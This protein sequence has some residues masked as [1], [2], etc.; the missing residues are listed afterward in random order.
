MGHTCMIWLHL[1]INGNNVI[2]TAK[3]SDMLKAAALE[4]ILWDVRLLVRLS[5]QHVEIPCVECGSLEC[6]QS[7]MY[8]A[9]LQYH[10][11]I[12]RFMYLAKL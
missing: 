6:S 10:L 12:I 11:D 1:Y 8:Q 3:E 4:I 9:E 5:K 7:F 2:Q